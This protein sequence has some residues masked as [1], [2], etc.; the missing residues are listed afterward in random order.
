MSDLEALPDNILCLIVSFILS[1]LRKLPSVSSRFREVCMMPHWYTKFVLELNPTRFLHG[2]GSALSFQAG[3]RNQVMIENPASF[4][5]KAKKGSISIPWRDFSVFDLHLMPKDGHSDNERDSQYMQQCIDVILPHFESME[6]SPATK[7]KEDVILLSAKR[8]FSSSRCESVCHLSLNGKVKVECPEIEETEDMEARGPSL[9]VLFLSRFRSL[10]YLELNFVCYPQSDWVSPSLRCLPNLVVLD[11]WR[12]EWKRESVIALGPNIELFRIFSCSLQTA[13]DLK[14]CHHRIRVLS[15]DCSH[16]LSSPDLLQ[17]VAVS[18]SECMV[19]LSHI[20]CS[21][22]CIKVLLQ[23]MRMNMDRLH[24]VYTRDMYKVFDEIQAKIQQFTSSKHKKI[25]N[26]KHKKMTILEQELSLNAFSD[27]LD[28]DDD[29]HQMNGNP[30]KVIY[31]KLNVNLFA[32]S[33]HYSLFRKLQ[34]TVVFKNLIYFN[35]FTAQSL[36]P[37]Q[38]SPNSSKISD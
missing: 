29:Q 21:S 12:C 24:I 14:A 17:Q 11:L 18:P 35:T 3:N 27:E 7:K 33:K 15:T 13:F 16:C 4:L 34:I 22:E 2:D 23:M 30:F 25:K 19:M 5:L 37:S 1:E 6:I 31:G 10:Q 38:F 36:T 32:A 20:R 9:S 28:D 26:R 8:M